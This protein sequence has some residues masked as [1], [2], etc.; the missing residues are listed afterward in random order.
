MDD[1]PDKPQPLD[2]ALQRRA[3]QL[4]ANIEKLAKALHATIGCDAITL[5]VSY[6]LA[7]P[8]EEGAE[9]MVWPITC[10]GT[11][12]SGQKSWSEHA[13]VVKAVVE[14]LIEKDKES[15]K[16]PEEPDKGN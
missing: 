14:R 7:A 6:T 13:T 4:N 3:A 11:S 12:A 9:S 1:K 5:A 10:M 15:R 8:D 2:E 16:D